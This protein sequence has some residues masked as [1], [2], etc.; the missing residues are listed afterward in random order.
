MPKPDDSDIE[1]ARSMDPEAK[2]Q[3][4]TYRRGMRR[5]ISGFPVSAGDAQSYGESPE[6]Q[7]NDLE[8]RGPR[9]GHGFRNS[10]VPPFVSYQ[11]MDQHHELNRVIQRRQHLRETVRGATDVWLPGQNETNSA[12]ASG[13][14]NNGYGSLWTG[15]NFRTPEQHAQQEVL[16]GGHERSAIQGK[17]GG[18]AFP[19]TWDKEARGHALKDAIA[20]SGDVTANPLVRKNMHGVEAANSYLKSRYTGTGGMS[21]TWRYN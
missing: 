7:G 16:R 15:D 6:P 17:E 13:H 9:G 8:S 12:S 4:R 5:G 2:E 20:G 19:P 11:K 3:E 1:Y 21:Q 10:S 14:R 18:G